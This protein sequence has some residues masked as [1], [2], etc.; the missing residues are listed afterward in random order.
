T[1]PGSLPTKRK[2]WS[3]QIPIATAHPTRISHLTQAPSN[4][5]S[6]E[7]PQNAPKQRVNPLEGAHSTPHSEQ[8]EDPQVQDHPDQGNT[9]DHHD[10]PQDSHDALPRN[11]RASSRHTRATAANSA[12]VT[13][14]ASNTPP[15]QSDTR[16]R[17]RCGGR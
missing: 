4:S 15:F 13:V 3:Q 10:V 1:V 6:H 11:C 9:D 8:L 16:G 17:L 12:A 5:A 14:E 2:S 7:A